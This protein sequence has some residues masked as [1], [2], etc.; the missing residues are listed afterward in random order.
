[1]DSAARERLRKALAT[2]DIND[3]AAV[4]SDR[5]R[6][7]EITIERVDAAATFGDSAAKLISPNTL[8]SYARVERLLSDDE[9]NIIAKWL[10]K[11]RNDYFL[12]SRFFTRVDD[13]PFLGSML[14][15][16]YNGL[17]DALLYASSIDDLGSVNRIRNIERQTDQRVAEMLLWGI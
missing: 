5:L 13:V 10:L 9:Q 12:R 7:G 11:Q 1:M 17:N 14:A 16:W 2:G 3:V 8:V 15:A 4:I 6:S